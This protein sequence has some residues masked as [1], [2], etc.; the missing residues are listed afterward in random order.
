[1][2]EDLK[3][4]NEWDKTFELSEKVNNWKNKLSNKKYY[5]V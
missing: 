5:E 3:I 2:N 4:S 1:M